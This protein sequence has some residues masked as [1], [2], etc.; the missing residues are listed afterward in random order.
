MQPTTMQSDQVLVHVGNEVRWNGRQT[1][2]GK[3]SPQ[4]FSSDTGK[5]SNTVEKKSAEKR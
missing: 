2:D 1:T 4:A 5:A 3:A